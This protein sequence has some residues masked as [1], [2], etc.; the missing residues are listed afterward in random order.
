MAETIQSFWIEG[1][2]TR[3]QL[4]TVHSFLQHGHKFVLY[5]YEVPAGLPRA[6]LAHIVA[7]LFSRGASAR[8]L[9]GNGNYQ[10]GTF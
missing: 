8:R 9:P 3:H 4:L 6:E 5:A 1:E 7:G 2:F 10:L